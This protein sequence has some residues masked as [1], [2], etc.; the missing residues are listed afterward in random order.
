MAAE[1][2]GTAIL[3]SA[4]MG[5]GFHS[6]GGEAVLGAAG[7]LGVALAAGIVLMALLYSFAHVSG[8]HFNPAVTVGL[9]AGGR[10]P[11]INTIPYIIAQCLGAAAAVSLFWF[12]GH[13]GQTFAANGYGDQSMLKVGMIQV[14]VMEAVLMAFFQIIIMGATRHGM[15]GLAPIAIGLT[16][17]A[18][19]I[20]TIPVDNAGFNPARSFGSA[21]F[22]GSVAWY[23]QWVFWA[24]PFLGAI[25]GSV[26]YNWIARDI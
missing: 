24:A 22:A 10:F 9:A 21:V 15:S 7:I 6:F 3:I 26:F 16:L 11:W 23:Q 8:G 20:M 14:F 4:G 13:T 18:L 2:V 25:I 19:I 5:A 17:T 1:F 12:I